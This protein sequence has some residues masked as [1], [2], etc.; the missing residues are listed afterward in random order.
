MKVNIHVA[1][2][3]QFANINNIA[4]YC[5]PPLPLPHLCG[6]KANIWFLVILRIFREINIAKRAFCSSV[7]L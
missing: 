6:Q 1:C 5:W 7:I 3:G 4:G 2:L